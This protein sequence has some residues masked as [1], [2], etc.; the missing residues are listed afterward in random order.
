MARWID[1]DLITSILDY[2]KTKNVF[3]AEAYVVYEDVFS[4]ALSDDGLEHLEK[5]KGGGVGIRVIDKDGKMGFAHANSFDPNILRSIADEALKRVSLSSPDPFR[6]FLFPSGDYP[7]VCIFDGSIFSFRESEKVSVVEEL[8]ERAKGSHPK[9]EKIRKA[10]YDDGVYEIALA[11]TEG[12]LLCKEG[13]FFSVGLAVLASGEGEKEMGYYG[14]EKRFFKDLDLSEVVEKTV[15][16][17][18]NLLGGKRIKSQRLPLVLSPEVSCDFISLFATLLSAE[19]V[20]KGKSLLA[21]KLGDKV[22]SS[23]FSLIDDGTIN[24]GMGSSPFDGEGFPTKRKEVIEKGILKTYLHNLYTASKDGVET[25][26]NAVRGYASVPSVGITNLFVMPGDKSPEEILRSVK[27][28]LYVVDVMGLHTVN[29][30][31]GDF[32][33]GVSG[34]WIENGEMVFPVKGISIAGN[35]LE[36]FSKIEDVGKDLIFFGN[37]GGVTLLVSDVMIGGE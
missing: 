5:S 6:K 4:A 26:G 13:T 20:Q 19:N 33:L 31:S 29:L 28:G 7:E 14:Q 16:K 24:R 11:N 27:R 9:I 22:A 2:L 36:L 3:F 30:I 25:T 12:M 37:V 17:A 21:N 34:L 23:H 18:V 15:E 8:Y 32:S 35:I 1:L 10:E